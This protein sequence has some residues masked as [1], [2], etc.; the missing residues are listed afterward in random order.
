MIVQ[1]TEAI[2][3]RGKIDCINK[4][5]KNRLKIRFKVKISGHL[6]KP[7]VRKFARTDVL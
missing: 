5:V 1:I 6:K 4:R 3:S 7:G 2:K